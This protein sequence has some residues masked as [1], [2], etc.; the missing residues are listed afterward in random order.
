MKYLLTLPALTITLASCSILNI[1]KSLSSPDGKIN[2][3]VHNNNGQIEYQISRDGEL[4]LESS[5]LGLVFTDRDLTQDL[6]SVSTSSTKLVDESY[7]L[8]SAKQKNIRYQANEKSFIF[9]NSAAQKL[10]VTF[11]VSDDGVAFK[12]TALGNGEQVQFSQELTS[13]NLPDDSRAW[14]QPIA[15]AQTGW[16]NTNPSYEEHYQ[17]DIPVDQ[18]SPSPAGWVFP[19]LYK[20]QSN[21]LALTEAG[22]SAN[23]HASRL[24]PS[25]ANGEYTLG[26]PMQ[27][28]V[29][30][31]SG[32]LAQGK[33][34]FSSPWRVLTIGDLKTVSESTLGTDL[35]EPSITM[36]TDFIKP[37]VSSWSWGLLKDDFTI[38]EVQKEF[39]DHAANMDWQYTLI[40]ADWDR[41]I[42]FEKLKELVEYG[43]S[44]NVGVLVWYNSS[45]S[46][47]QTQYSPKGQLL[48]S[49]LR[50]QAFSQLKKLGVKGVKIDFFAGDGQSMIAYY[51][52]ILKD[53]AQYEL[54]VNFHGAT[55][56]RGLHK[57]YPHLMTAEAVKG[58][59]MVT[60]FQD[61]ADKVASHSSV[62]PFTRNLF[63]PMDYTP[64][65]FNPIPNIERKTTNA[66]QLAQAIIFVSGIQHIVETPQGMK[67]VPYFAKDIL[68]RLPASWDE[69]KF[70]SGYPGKLAVFARRSGDTW[71]VAGINGENKAKSIELDLSFL[72]GQNLSLI[73]QGPGVKGLKMEKIVASKTTKVTLAGNDG[74]V[75]TT[76]F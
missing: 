6:Q 74:F 54:L 57:T 38:F 35:A 11:R 68:S 75:M 52:E 42:G 40:D 21:W 41:K 28:E 19:A 3:H 15:E 5:K 59:E 60:F 8:Y 63:D 20:T 7:Q 24:A 46:W 2:V 73:S 43:Q 65:T 76:K 70:I 1:D 62:L 47:N 44:K 16:A 18:S 13:F 67:S 27:A 50:H 26:Q 56:P 14:L 64:T 49:E 61:S 30:T 45:G 23:F 4:V 22:I 25:S 51:H 69:S 55:L 10:K 36:N 12:Y 31:N 48:T 9:Q 53:A 71:Y 34:P 33:L 72:N 29:F 37:G 39:I 32:R 66:L 58:F 17:I